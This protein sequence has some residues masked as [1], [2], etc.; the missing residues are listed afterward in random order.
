MTTAE[1]ARADDDMRRK[2]GQTTTAE[3]TKTDFDGGG[4]YGEQQHREWLQHTQS[5]DNI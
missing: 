5:V 1:N 2:L 4:G 3:E